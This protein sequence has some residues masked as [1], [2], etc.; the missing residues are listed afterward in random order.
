MSAD[1]GQLRRDTTLLIVI[2]VLSLIA[3]AGSFYTAR[4]LQ[5]PPVVATM[6][7]DGGHVP[8]PAGPR[9]YQ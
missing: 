8:L 3:G 6:G 5:A 7:E 9:K 4:Q 1:S 2:A